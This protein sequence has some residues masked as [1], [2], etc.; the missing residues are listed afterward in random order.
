MHHEG[1]THLMHSH[2][3]PLDNHT[4]AALVAEVRASVVRATLGPPWT[5]SSD[6][7]RRNHRVHVEPRHVGR[8][9]GH[10]GAGYSACMRKWLLMAV[11]FPMA[12]W[13]LSRI[14]DEI[15]E[16]RGESRATA[17]LRYPHEWRHSRRHA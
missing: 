8:G 6:R 10:S 16:S 15:A 17:M 9:F 1:G 5:K 3:E 13:L 11:A 7:P 14:A 2:G 12:A 4:L